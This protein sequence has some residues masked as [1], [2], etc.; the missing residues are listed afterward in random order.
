M[1]QYTNIRLE[2][3]LKEKLDKLVTNKHETYNDIV[4]KIVTEKENATGNMSS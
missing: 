3:T 1:K 2:V 4:K